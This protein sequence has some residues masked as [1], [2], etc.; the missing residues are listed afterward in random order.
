MLIAARKLSW[1]DDKAGCFV[2]LDFRPPSGARPATRLQRGNELRLISG[3]GLRRPR[4]GLSVARPASRPG[5][6]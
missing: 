3:I 6:S 5:S 1:A 4:W 2:L